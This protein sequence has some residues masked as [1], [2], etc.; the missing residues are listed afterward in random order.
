MPYRNDYVWF[1]QPWKTDYRGTEKFAEEVFGKLGPEAIVYA[2]NTMVYPLLYMQEIKGERVDI[3][4]I[5]EYA[6]SE[7]VPLLNE[8][9][10]KQWQAETDVYAVSPVE[11]IKGQGVVWKVEN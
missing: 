5:S 10:I 8:K 4:I 9:S 11:G 3:K 1:M 6:S 2:D 7:S